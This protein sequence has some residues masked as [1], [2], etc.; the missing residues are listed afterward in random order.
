[1]PV[2]SWLRQLSGFRWAAPAGWWPAWA[3][4]TVAA[5][6]ALLAVGAGFAVRPRTEVVPVPDRGIVA[7]LASGQVDRVDVSF[8]VQSEVDIR[9]DPTASGGYTRRRIPATNQ[10]I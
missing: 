10:L 5:V 8:T 6:V 9:V 3:R 1:M 4:T 2:P 7:V